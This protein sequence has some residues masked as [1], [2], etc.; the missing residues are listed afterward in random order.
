MSDTKVDDRL[1]NWL[2]GSD[3]KV[4]DRLVNWLTEVTNDPIGYTERVITK[5][6]LE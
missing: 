4:D 2:T 1:V 6:E 3:K 5:G